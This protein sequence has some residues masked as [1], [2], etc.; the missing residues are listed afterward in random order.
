MALLLVS[1]FLVYALAWVVCGLIVREERRAIALWSVYCL[2]QGAGLY[3][4]I[5]SPPG[6]SPIPLSAS[7][8][9]L[10]SYACAVVGVD[11]F[12][13][14]GRPKFLGLWLTLLGLGEA[15]QAAVPL[16]EL[17]PHLQ[18]VGFNLS[19]A[20]LLAGPVLVLQRAMRR[21]FGLW[22]LLP[23]VPGGLLCV[24]ALA[25][26]GVILNNPQLALQA[27]L[28][29]AENPTMLLTT[30]F[31]A[32]AFNVSFLSLVV[33]RMVKRMHGL[34]DRD[35]LTG[36]ANRGGLEKRLSAAW[37][38]GTRHGVILSVAF[39]DIDDFKQI[40]DIGGH[41]AGDLVIQGVASALQQGAR[42]T[43][44]VGRWGGD[45][46]MLVMPHTGPDEAA[47]A[48][49]RLRE[50]VREA[51][52]PMPPGCPALTLSIGVATRLGTDASVQ[53]LVMRADV[54]MYRSKK[55]RPAFT[56]EAAPEA[57]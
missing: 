15:T 2:L 7:M 14:D 32:G 47:H 51:D 25:R 56:A 30:L 13:H 6:G 23:A 41:E 55:M 49:Q 34:L 21:E 46:F 31:A 28:R 5:T 29:F 50:R 9:M 42:N 10:V 54:A 35:A 57:V 18:A 19:V 40:N 38:N 27:A 45:E 39:I 1:Q 33:G 8:L 52:I 53:A 20:M 24:L 48:M 37:D 36:L 12:T 11:V 3:L 22:G 17:P 16:F 26:C 43:D 44:H 4:V